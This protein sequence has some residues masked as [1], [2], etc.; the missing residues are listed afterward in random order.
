M[1]KS[2]ALVATAV[3]FVS[4][5]SIMS[6]PSWALKGE[7]GAG[8]GVD[9]S[10]IEFSFR[11]RGTGTGTTATGAWKQT[12]AAGTHRGEISCMHVVTTASGRSAILSGT[13]TDSTNPA[14]VGAPFT[15]AAFDGA[16]APDRY[17]FDSFSPSTCAS[18]SSAANT[19]QEGRITLRDA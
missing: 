5:L 17:S 15:F 16:T 7:R 18:V 3:L 6:G 1:R 12:D 4:F 2:T 10:G 19:L 9:S 14:A 8:R 11:A 13:V